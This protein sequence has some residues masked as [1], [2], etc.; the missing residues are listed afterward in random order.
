MILLAGCN[1]DRGDTI[2]P[3]I[4]YTFP[5]EFTIL[6]NIATIR[7]KA[8][9]NEGIKQV[10]F[11]ADGDT[12]GQDSQEPYA[13]KWNTSAF[14]DCTDTDSYILLTAAAVDFAGNVGTAQRKYF[15]DNEGLPPIRVE[16][17]EPSNVTKHS[18]TLTWEKSLDWDFSHYI[19]R[20]DT[21]ATV[22]INADSLVRFDD[23]DAT[24][25]AD[26]GEGISPFGLLEDT[27]YHYRIFV[28]DTFGR[29]RASDSTVT[30][31]TLLPQ[32]VKLV[33]GE[34][35][36]PKSTVR[37]QWEPSEEDVAYFRLHRGLVPQPVNLDSIAAFTPRPGTYTYL[38]TGLVADSTYYYYL[39]LVDEA[40]Y[41]HNFN[42][43]N[44]VE[45]RTAALPEPVLNT[46]LIITK[47]SATIAW[48]AIHMQ[49]DFSWITLYRSITASV[50]TNDVVIYTDLRNQ[51]PAYQDTSLSQG[52]T[53]Y[54]RMY[55]IDTRNNTAWSNTLALTTRSL[56]DVWQG[57]L[58]VGPPGKYQLELV[59]TPYTWTVEDDFTR[60]ILTNN[61]DV[62]Q[63]TSDPNVTTYTH[64]GLQ[65]NTLYSYT[66]TVN[67]SSGASAT[68]TLV[69]A[70]RDIYP[71]KITRLEPDSLWHFNIEW[72]P[73]Q[74][75]SG[76]FLKYVLL[77]TDDENETFE[78]AN[79]DNIPDCLPGG[80]CIKVTETT[81]RL[82]SAGD[83]T[84]TFNDSDTN[85]V[86]QQ[87]YNYVL[88][89]YDQQGDWTPSNIEG[90]VLSSPPKPVN[91]F[92][93]GGTSS[94]ISL[95]WSRATWGSPIDDDKLFSRYEL[96]RSNQQGVSPDSVNAP[97]TLVTAIND[98]GILQYE[99]GDGALGQILWHYIVVLHDK[100]GQAAISNEV[101]GVT[102]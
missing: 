47:Y 98:I 93:P 17:F 21:A 28:H 40:G 76:E 57:G 54:Y 86:K 52:Q 94:T 23:P 12:V 24:S 69:A 70:T 99:D 53:Y 83:S 1:R 61:G 32:P 46:P 96:W 48:E 5:R 85:L 9:D 3:S 78:D 100:F 81:Q 102:L 62:L 11:M 35:P 90:E 29:F 22:T 97:N 68:A 4:S 79:S 38:D 77:R 44:V 71:A 43:A 73:S 80:N 10:I 31:H 50:D 25:F 92:D 89:T 19:L 8:G 87:K 34:S 15:L 33:T 26:T 65:K 27:E 30:I 2:A 88:L 66:L 59:W 58:G 64:T 95:S 36:R 75:T 13:L 56:A 42:S 101:I 20:R 41:T 6:S 72:L 37:L 60:Y 84:L 67:D 49:E 14:P 51:L 16:M 82:P 63:S 91:L 45:A 74:E 55:H 7:V 18:A 39:Y